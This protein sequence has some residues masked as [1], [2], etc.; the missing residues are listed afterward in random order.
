[1]KKNILALFL[2]G[3]L[4]A[5]VFSFAQVVGDVDPNPTVSSC[6][7][8]D[9]NLRYRDRDVNN[10]GEISTLQDFLQ[11]KNY[12]NSEPTGYFGLLTFKAIKDF[13]KDNNISPT[14]YVGEITKAKIKA[15]SCVETIP[16]NPNNPVISGVSGPQKLDV[17]QTGT[18]TVSA[19][20]ST[21]GNLSYSVIWG[22]EGDKNYPAS[23]MPRYYNIQQTATFTHSYV[24]AG[25]YTPTF[26]VTSENTIR[27]ITTPCPGNEGSAKT[28]LSVNVGNVLMEELNN[29]TSDSEINH[30]NKKSSCKKI[31]I[32]LKKGIEDDQVKCLQEMLIAKGFKI[33]GVEKGMET[34]FFGSKTLSALK[35]FQTKNQ[36]KADGIFG[37][38][39]REVL[40]KMEQE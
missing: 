29:N 1:M 5:P 23:L 36:L 10:S 38:S 8:L 39:S 11:S 15:L 16:T 9:N 20:S 17:N 40:E 30:V 13:Q 35:E 19:S 37:P 31:T 7:T 27:C 12:L 33:E 14:G 24:K 6:L 2:V 28:S 21:T 22:D 25:I 4:L 26:T 34:T 18:W 3:F 32:T